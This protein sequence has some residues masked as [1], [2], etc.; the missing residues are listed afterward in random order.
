MMINRKGIILSITISIIALICSFCFVWYQNKATYELQIENFNNIE[1][2]WVN[3]T[4]EEQDLFKN[5]DN[6]FDLENLPEN[7]Y[8]LVT[9]E[10][11]YEEIDT[12][13]IGHYQ[14]QIILTLN[15]T[16]DEQLFRTIDVKYSICSVDLNPVIENAEDELILLCGT[17]IEV[18]SDIT[19]T[20]CYGVEISVMVDI[21]SVDSTNQGYNEF[22]YVAIDENGNET[23]VTAT[24]IYVNEVANI[25]E[26]NIEDAVHPNAQDFLDAETLYGLTAE[27]SEELNDFSEIGSFDVPIIVSNENGD[28][29]EVTGTLVIR[30]ESD[31]PIIT[32]VKS[33]GVSVGDSVTYKSGVSAIDC[34]GNELSL[35][36]DNSEVDLN[37]TGTYEISYTAT[38]ENENET[39]VYTTITVSNIDTEYVLELIDDILDEII[40]DSMSDYDKAYAAYKWCT[41]NITY[42]SSGSHS[43]IYEIAYYGLTG[44]PGDCYTYYSVL[45]LMMQQLDI[46]VI[47]MERI[48]GTSSNHKWIAINLGDGWYHVDACPNSEASNTF[49]FTDTKATYYTYLQ[50]Q[51]HGYSYHYY[52]YK[53]LADGITIVS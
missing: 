9:T 42:A 49:M 52:D 5:S 30:Y 40:D 47:T 24:A 27:F 45:Y 14:T 41:N 31:S 23:T 3:G 2:V 36:V 25:V 28:S 1:S 50:D 19:A 51:K 10:F 29:V 37:T 38:D 26:V 43:D 8:G 4:I 48:D 17:D 33:L 32:G 44:S 16:D 6:Y 35:T 12:D 21:D 15:I 34:Y 46:P 20:D 39:T 53:D 11:S 18:S 22:N 13:N 7:I